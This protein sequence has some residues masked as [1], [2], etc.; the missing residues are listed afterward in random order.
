MKDTIPDD[1]KT[2]IWLNTFTILVLG[3]KAIRNAISYPSLNRLISSLFM[4]PTVLFSSSL[5]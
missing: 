4:G 3:C 5:N 2:K 1:V